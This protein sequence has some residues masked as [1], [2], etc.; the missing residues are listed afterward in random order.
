MALS[1]GQSSE[2]LENISPSWSWAS[3]NGRPKISGSL[4]PESF[5]IDEDNS[6][7][8][9]IIYQLRVVAVNCTYGTERSHGIPQVGILRV[10][11]YVT[12]VSFDENHRFTA[13]GHNIAG[14][15][16]E[17][18]PDVADWSEFQKHNCHFLVVYSTIASTNTQFIGIVTN[19]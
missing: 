18:R 3:V 2:R 11:G 13:S 7:Q 10:V 17:A 12:E 15:T 16:M 9:K 19:A 1:S 5:N 6:S 8:A 4:D 14:S